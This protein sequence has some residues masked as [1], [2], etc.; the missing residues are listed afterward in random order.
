MVSVEEKAQHVLRKIWAKETNANE[1]TDDV[2]KRDKWHQNLGLVNSPWRST[3]ETCLLSV[4]CPA[5][6]YCEL[7]LGSRAERGNLSS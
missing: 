4:R 5:Y 3:E 1:I 7:G 6:R 2:S